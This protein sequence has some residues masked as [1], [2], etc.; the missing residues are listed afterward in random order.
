[1]VETMGFS[2]LLA[3]GFIESG[4]ASKFFVVF[5]YIFHPNAELT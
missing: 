4:L 5:A 2:F 3:P 1:M